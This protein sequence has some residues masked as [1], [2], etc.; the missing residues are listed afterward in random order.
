MGKKRNFFCKFEEICNYIGSIISNENLTDFGRLLKG[1]D[2][3]DDGT[4]SRGNFYE[5][6]KS[7]P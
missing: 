5:T 4:I 7:I 3:K 2:F 6:I 1:Q